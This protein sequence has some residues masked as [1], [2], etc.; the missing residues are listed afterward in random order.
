MVLISVGIMIA[1]SSS[2]ITKGSPEAVIPL[3]DV[4]LTPHSPEVPVVIDIVTA[5]VVSTAV[6]FTTTQVP[7]TVISCHLGKERNTISKGCVS[8]LW[9]EWLDRS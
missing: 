2:T 4:V 5:K 9:W 1:I 8:E 6:L 3:L 7:L